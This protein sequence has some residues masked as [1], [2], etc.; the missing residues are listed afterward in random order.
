MSQYPPL[1]VGFSGQV[2]G[3]ALGKPV[4]ARTAGWHRRPSL[5]GFRRRGRVNADSSHRVT[6]TR[7]GASI[8][9][10]RNG[11]MFMVREIRVEALRLR[12]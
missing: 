7:C 4:G 10:E 3:I 8:K 6:A 2:R 9:L 11:F 12:C 1:F 5:P